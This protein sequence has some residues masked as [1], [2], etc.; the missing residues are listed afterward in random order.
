MLVL[1][2]AVVWKEPKPRVDTAAASKAKPEALSVCVGW[3]RTAAPV[4]VV[5][6][7]ELA[8]ETVPATEAEPDVGSAG[9]A[10]V[11]AWVA[12]RGL[13]VLELLVTA[14]PPTSPV[15]MVPTSAWTTKLA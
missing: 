11:K 6:R 15:L 3:I 7:V 10:K 9:I 14:K 5:G 13:E 4:V 8:R 12:G 1:G 2:A